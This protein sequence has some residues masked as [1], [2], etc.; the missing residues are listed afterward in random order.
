MHPR[1]ETLNQFYNR[2][3]FKTFRIYDSKSK[4]SWI[5]TTR[6]E[7]KEL[8]KQ[9]SQL[10]TSEIIHYVEVD[11]FMKS[12]ICETFKFIFKSDLIIDYSNLLELILVVNNLC[13]LVCL[14]NQ[15]RWLMVSKLRSNSIASI[16]SLAKVR[17]E[18]LIVADEL[19]TS[20][21]QFRCD[22]QNLLIV[23]YNR[24]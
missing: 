8:F 11:T 16:Y 22:N 7:K 17:K 13:P 5:I 4:Q 3:T 15:F 9:I 12:T 19:K 6:Y 23:W 21:L 20:N 18:N 24:K 1:S 10:Y 14:I 2:L